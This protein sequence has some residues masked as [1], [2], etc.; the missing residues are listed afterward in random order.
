MLGKSLKR[1]TG[2]CKSVQEQRRRIG[3]CASLVPGRID[4]QSVILES[5]FGASVAF[6]S[7]WLA[8]LF[9]ILLEDLH[10]SP[11]VN[12]RDLLSR[13]TMEVLNHRVN[14]LGTNRL[15]VL[16]LCSVA[17]GGRGSLANGI[18]RISGGAPMDKCI[19]M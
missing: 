11:A 18:R 16:A 10:L 15:F 9:A 13:P 1:G 12:H 6:V 8:A 4:K 19:K 17:R 14:V 5:S 2:R 3:L 7:G